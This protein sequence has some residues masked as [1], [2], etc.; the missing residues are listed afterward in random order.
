MTAGIRMQ[1]CP[2]SGSEMTAARYDSVGECM[3][4]PAQAY[5]KTTYLITT[6][7][8]VPRGTE[9]AVSLEGTAAGAAAAALFAGGSFALGQVQQRRAAMCKVQADN[10]SS[11]MAVCL[12]PFQFAVTY[13]LAI[14][15]VSQHRLCANAQACMIM[16]RSSA[17]LGMCCRCLCKE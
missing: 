17:T 1:R 13:K 4:V 2:N 11:A 15:I 6:L 7:K 9:G 14:N 3:H 8:T 12:F 10:K 16:S 5:G